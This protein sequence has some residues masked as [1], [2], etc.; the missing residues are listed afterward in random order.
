MTYNHLA[1]F[2]GL[3]GS[4]HCAV[5]CGPLLLTFNGRTGLSWHTL[6]NSL[7]YQSG[8]ILTYGI[9]GFFLSLF[10]RMATVQGWQQSL[11]LA[12]GVLLIAFALSAFSGTKAGWGSS[13]YTQGLKRAVSFMGQW[14]GRPGGAVVVGMLNGFLPCGMVYMALASAMS[15]ASPAQGFLFMVLFGLGTLP[16][17]LF[18]SFIGTMPIALRKQ[19]FGRIVP[20]LYLLMGVWFILRGANLDIPYLSPLLYVEGA[21]RCS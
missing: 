18:F 20:F 1:F 5:M 21:I 19:R 14:F 9:F 4:L 8:R 16:L 7:L 2:M 13:F 10:G 12:V 6:G 15:S 17:L 11:S 3:F